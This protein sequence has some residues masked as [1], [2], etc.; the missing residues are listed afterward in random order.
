M[1][2][3]P[4]IWNGRFIHSVVRTLLRGAVASQR[5]TPSVTYLDRSTPVS[6]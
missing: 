4:W 3:D 6:R 2:D 5:T 1:P